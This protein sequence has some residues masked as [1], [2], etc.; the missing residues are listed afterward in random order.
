MG[1]TTSELLE[2]A[3]TGAFE[4]DNF[5]DLLY[6]M[7]LA[8]AWEGWAEVTLL[9]H[10]R[11]STEPLLGRP[12]H[13]AHL[14]LNSKRFDAV[15]L[16]GGASVPIAMAKAAQ[17]QERPL[18]DSEPYGRGIVDDHSR[19]PFV[20]DV[21]DTACNSDTPVFLNSVSVWPTGPLRVAH[22]RRLQIALHG[23]Q[24]I[25]V[26]NRPSLEFLRRAWGGYPAAL[27][28]DS[29]HALSAHWPLDES[30]VDRAGLWCSRKVNSWTRWVRIRWLPG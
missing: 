6:P 17:M 21:I 12:V 28:P 29:V 24:H 3:V 25:T 16:A 4:R 5:G 27:Q 7:L 18:D 23:A 14:M 13:D 22:R 11:A 20:P 1:R 9:S 8:D 15:V 30:R 10:F 2:V 26:R 19:M